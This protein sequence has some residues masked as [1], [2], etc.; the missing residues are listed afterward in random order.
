MDF[1]V[2]RIMRRAEVALGSFLRHLSAEFSVPAES[3][4]GDRA[5]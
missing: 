4:I 2:G 3:N 1:R 5:K